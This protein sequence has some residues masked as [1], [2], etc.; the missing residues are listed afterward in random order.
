[1]NESDYTQA[2]HKRLPA[3]VKAWKIRDDYQG[4]VADAFYRRRDGEKGT[5]L[6]IE[7]KYI[8]TLPKRDTTMI[9][10]DLSELQKGWL[11]EAE[12]AGEEVRV[13]IGYGSEG[14]MLSLDEAVGGV[15]KADFQQRLEPY[16][17]I[18]LA[19][20]NIVMNHA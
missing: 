12:Q 14:V 1:M 15:S 17:G 10:A 16:K 13:I 18:S 7:Y 8:K 2:V 9:V 4:G 19:I 6:W 3:S 11:K 20:T 5:P